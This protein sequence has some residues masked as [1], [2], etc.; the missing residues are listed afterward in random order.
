MLLYRGRD[1]QAVNPFHH[2][3]VAGVEH[4]AVPVPCPFCVVGMPSVLAAGRMCVAVLGSVL[5]M[6]GLG[7]CVPCL[8]CMRII[9]APGVWEMPMPWGAVRFCLA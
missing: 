6:G 3:R 4:V 2:F 8:G 9:R 7:I 1:W 5:S